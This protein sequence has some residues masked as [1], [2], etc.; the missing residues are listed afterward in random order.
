M[1][2]KTIEPAEMPAECLGA[3]EKAGAS[4]RDFLRT[5]GVMF[6]GFGMAGGARKLA[7][8]DPT[9]P[10][11]LVDANQVDSWLAIGADESITAYSGKIDFGQGFRTVQHQL[12]AEELSVPLDRITLIMGVT[13]VTPDQGVTSGSQSHIAEFGPGGLRQAL[14][15]ARD[16][17]MQLA[18]Q[19]L[20]APASAL[21]VKAGVVY[22]KSD[23]TQQVTYG[24]LVQGKRF[25]LTLNNKAVPKDPSQYRVLGTSVRRVDIPAK[26]TGQFQYVQHVRVP[27]MLH[28]KVVRPRTVG[29]TVVSVDN[30]SLAGMPGRPQV[31]VR[32]NFVGVV[33]DTEWHALQAANALNVTWSSGAALPAFATLY[34]SMRKQPSR[35]S[36]TVNSGDVDQALKSA[37]TTVKSTYLHPYQMHGSIGTSC[38]VADVRGGNGPNATAR[39]WS[40]SQ[41]VYPQ[42]D[43]V[44]NVL[45]IPNTNVRVIFVEGSGCY[46]I[47]GADTVSYDAA[48]LSQAVGAPVRVQFT[49]RDEMTAGENYGPAHVMDMSA[50]LDTN[51]QVLTWNYEGWTLSKGGRPSAAAP[52]NIISGALAGFPTP[53]FTPAAATPPTTFSNNG[54][55]APAYVTGAVN[56]A[57]GGTGNVASQRVLVHTI[58]SAFFTGPLRSPDRL[59]NTFANE[60]FMD[61]LATAAKDDP[62]QYRLRHLTDA[63]LIAVLK[64]AASHAGW[65]PRPSP[66]P[67]NARTGVVTGRGVS[68]L[69]YEGNNGYSALVAEVQVDQAAGT[70]TVTRLVAAQDSGPVSNPDGL[71]NQMEGGALQGMSRALHEEVKWD[72]QAG[73]I[74][75]FDWR[76][77]AVYQFGDTLP[78]VET[79]VLDR[80]NVPQMGAGECIITTVAAAIGNAVFDAAGVRL[81]Q[82]P[83]TPANFLAAKS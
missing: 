17:L 79:V 47:N 34:D 39:I 75:T 37:A 51:G 42:R 41:G 80:K 29:A 68:C 70:I 53:A 81:R 62:V 12:I 69:L 20:D 74:T 56:G 66:K 52:G 78:V 54:N 55:T 14:D 24:Q 10:T 45:G 64:A 59:Q 49:R 73:F 71:R 2:P 60:S 9:N 72:E 58:E 38:A 25:N 8:Q 26:V 6:I 13:G 40:A 5:A 28:G 63:R 82:V 1:K 21:A 48:L 3:L 44:A 35:D 43:S 23:P 33:A 67:G 16:A 4:R 27:G 11:A 18:S 31:V 15:T 30:G 65:D 22:M 76:R 57:A 61:E 46:G 19:Q 32:R 50:G 36:Y 83:F 77:Y 7:A